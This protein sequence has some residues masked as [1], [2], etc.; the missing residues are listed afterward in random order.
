MDDKGSSRVGNNSRPRFQHRHQMEEG[1]WVEAGSGTCA[2]VV[3]AADD[4]DVS[5]C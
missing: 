2:T 4:D 5:R 1:T 3:A